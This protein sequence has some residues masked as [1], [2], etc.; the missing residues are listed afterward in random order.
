MVFPFGMYTVCTFQLANAIGFP[1]LLVIPR[2]FIYLALAGWIGALV[3]LM[4]T[5]L[6]SAPRVEAK[7]PRPEV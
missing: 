6:R 3:G 7:Q 4:G 5:L 1:R 2:Y